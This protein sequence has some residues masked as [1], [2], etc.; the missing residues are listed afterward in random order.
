MGSGINSMN[1]E[2]AQKLK[3]AG[4]PKSKGRADEKVFIGGA[5]DEWISPSLSELIKECGDKFK[6][7]KK[8]RTY[9]DKLDEDGNVLWIATTDELVEGGYTPEEAVAKLWLKLNE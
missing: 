3:D 9:S 6:E 5:G 4:F 8:S 7:L 2:L 1:R